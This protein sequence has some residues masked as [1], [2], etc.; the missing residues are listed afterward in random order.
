MQKRFPAQKAA[1]VNTGG[2]LRRSRRK[3][4]EQP[5]AVRAAVFLRFRSE[6]RAA[7]TWKRFHA[8]AYHAFQK[9]SIGCGHFYLFSLLFYDSVSLRLLFSAPGENRELLPGCRSGHRRL[10]HSA[11]SPKA[12]LAPAGRPAPSAG[13]TKKRRTS[14]LRSG[15]L[16]LSAARAQN[17]I[18]SSM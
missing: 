9:I 10:P 12:G 1:A 18:L 17:A 4:E 16:C 11:R 3:R 7:F 6:K 14:V 13:S 5:A 8:K 15:N 2:C